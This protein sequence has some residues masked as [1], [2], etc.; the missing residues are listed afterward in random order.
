MAA[1]IDRIARSMRETDLLGTRSNLTE[2]GLQY[3]VRHLH[4]TAASGTLRDAARIPDGA[5]AQSALVECREGINIQCPFTATRNLLNADT[6]GATMVHTGL[7]LHP[8]IVIAWDGGQPT[9]EG[10][11]AVLQDFNSCGEAPPYYPEWRQV[12]PTCAY[13][14]VENTALRTFTREQALADFADK[15]RTTAVGWNIEFNAP[16]IVDQGYCLQSQSPPNVVEQQLDGVALGPVLTVMKR[17]TA[18]ALRNRIN[19]LVTPELRPRFLAEC[20]DRNPEKGARRSPLLAR[21]VR[22]GGAEVTVRVQIQKDGLVLCELPLTGTWEQKLG[23]VA[24][25]WDASK[26]WIPPEWSDE[27]E[28]HPGWTKFKENLVI[29]GEREVVATG[30]NGVS[31]TLTSRSGGYQIW[32]AWY[33]EVEAGGYRRRALTL[34]FVRLAEGADAGR[35]PVVNGRF[36][37]GDGAITGDIHLSYDTDVDL[38]HQQVG[39]LPAL[40]LQNQIQTNPKIT[41]TQLKSGNG[42]SGSVCLWNPVWEPQDVQKTS[43]VQLTSTQVELDSGTRGPTDLFDKNAGQVVINACGMSQ[44]TTLFMQFSIDTEMSAQPESAIAPFMVEA[45]P[46]DKLA[47][48]VVRNMRNHMPWGFDGDRTRTSGLIAV[49]ARVAMAI[50]NHA[51]KNLGVATQQVVQDAHGG[52]LTGLAG[53]AL[54][55]VGLGFLKKPVSSVLGLAGGL[56]NKLI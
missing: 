15:I 29:P 24:G 33:N 14:A 5:F 28:T 50:A 38:G 21:L 27:D 39:E 40:D 11:Q 16:T 35:L 12:L 52:L 51:A 42:V 25:T 41:I 22:T 19:R 9:R 7:I 17:M 48:D 13:Y 1:P 46:T 56:L 34:S 31:V 18:R 54:Q 23:P 43:P 32:G 53:T 55:T 4:T 6:W 44:A 20:G 8:W 36:I 26:G 2:G 49:F 47:T 37:P 10:E 3:I 45:G 30:I